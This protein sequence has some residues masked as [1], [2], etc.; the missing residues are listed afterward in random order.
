M[1]DFFNWIVNPAVSKFMIAQ[2]GIQYLLISIG[3]FKIN[4]SAYA[5]VFFGYALA[6][7]GLYMKAT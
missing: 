7:V 1:T 5:I 2:I 6:N 4:D 3:N